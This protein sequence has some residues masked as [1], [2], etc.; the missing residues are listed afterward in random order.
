LGTTALR[1]AQGERTKKTRLAVSFSPFEGA[2]GFKTSLGR[3]TK[4]G[5]DYVR[6]LLIQGPRR[7]KAQQGRL[8]MC[9]LFSVLVLKPSH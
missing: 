4:R 2:W 6:T 7:R 9:S 5:D 1:Q 3:I 8:S